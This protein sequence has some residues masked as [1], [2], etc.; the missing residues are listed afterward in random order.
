LDFGAAS[1]L[2]FYDLR[3]SAPQ[4]RGKFVPEPAIS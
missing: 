1:T 3:L 2:P 4:D